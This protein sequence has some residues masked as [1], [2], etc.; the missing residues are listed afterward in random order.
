M[1]KIELV[2]SLITQVYE[3]PHRDSSKLDALQQRAKMITR[4]V[5]G[6][7]SKYLED[8]GRIHFTPWFAPATEHQHDENWKS[9]KS[10]MLNLFNTMLEE[11]EISASLEQPSELV[12]SDLLQRS[13]VVSSN[14]IFVAHG[15]DEEMKQA[16]ARTLETVG[17]EPVILHEEPSQGRTLIEKFT[18]HSDVS[19]A[20]VLLSP[21]DM[22]YPRDGSQKDARPRARQNVIFELGFFVGKLGRSHV[23][24]L[25]REDSEFEMLSDYSGV[26]YT[27]YDGGSGR[28][29]FELVRELKACGYDVDANKL[30]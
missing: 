13:K 29:R 14:R 10:E 15:H 1:N 17:L 8:L 27:P 24:A 3:L 11:L 16:A 23:F 28:W 9:G 25:N 6:P 7:S 22:A 30:V 21:D 19:F 4:T 18:D 26:V 20:V 5:F 2:Q 12:K